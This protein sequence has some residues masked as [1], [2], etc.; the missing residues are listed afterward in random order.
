MKNYFWAIT[1]K[2]EF[3]KTMMYGNEKWF[4]PDIYSTK[5]FAEDDL[6]GWLDKKDYTVVKVKI[7]LIK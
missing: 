3:S 7:S 4:N 1:K 2:G 6:N 5:E